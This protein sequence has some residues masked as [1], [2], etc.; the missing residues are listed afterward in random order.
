MIAFA[1]RHLSD[2]E[3]WMARRFVEELL[4]QRRGG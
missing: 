3:K 4:K 2:E 1:G